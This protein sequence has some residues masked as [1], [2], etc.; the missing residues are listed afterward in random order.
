MTVCV[1]SAVCAFYQL[2]WCHM[3]I[4]ASHATGNC[5]YNSF[6]RLT[7]KKN[8]SAALLAFC[9]GNPQVACRFP[10]QRASNA[11]SV[12][13]SWCHHVDFTCLS[14]FSNQM[15]NTLR[16]RQNGRH[17]ADDI[18][19]CIFLNENVWIS[20]KFSLK[21]VPRVQI[22]NILARWQAIIWTNDG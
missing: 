19:K 5:L 18:F 8:L 22:N 14:S 21:F 1:Y 15:L 20:L 12:S 6:S 4:M 11:E 7:S 3:S 16:P 9:D 10:S 17:F 13:M 2:Q